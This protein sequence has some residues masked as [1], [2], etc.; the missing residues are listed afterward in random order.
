MS[1]LISLL[2]PLVAVTTVLGYLPQ[3]HKLLVATRRPQNVSLTSWVIWTFSGLISF[4]YG[5]AV[6][7]DF[8]FALTAGLNA[9]FITITACL[10]AYNNYIRFE[11][12]DDLKEKILNALPNVDVETQIADKLATSSLSKRI[13]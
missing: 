13:L 3:I 9:A 1:E 5:V 2:Y 12:K 11:D 6:L 10:I 4:A 8:M 7:Q